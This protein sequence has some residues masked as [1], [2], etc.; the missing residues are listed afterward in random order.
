MLIVFISISISI[1][2]QPVLAAESP[3][4]PEAGAYFNAMCDDQAYLNY[5]QQVFQ[6]ADPATSA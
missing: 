3:V 5:L 4:L 2:Q 1:S 6:I